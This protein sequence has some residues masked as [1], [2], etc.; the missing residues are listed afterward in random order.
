MAGLNEDDLPHEPDN[1][2][3]TAPT[4]TLSELRHIYTSVQQMHVSDSPGIADLA[5]VKRFLKNLVDWKGLGLEL[6]LLYPSLKKIEVDQRGS[7]E[8]CK[9]EMLASWLQEQHNDSQPSWSV[10]RAALERIGEK[11]LPHE[12]DNDTNTAPTS[13]L[14]EL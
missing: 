7:V 8:Q 10:L 6:G 12:P 4:S 5:E 9:T 3:N 13:T 2:T 14:S 1:D 11:D